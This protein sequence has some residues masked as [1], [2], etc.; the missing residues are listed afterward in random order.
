MPKT[1]KSRSSSTSPPSSPVSPPSPNVQIPLSLLLISVY[2]FLLPLLGGFM[3]DLKPAALRVLLLAAAGV[4]LY[5]AQKPGGKPWNLWPGWPVALFLAWAILTTLTGAGWRS[6]YTTLHFLGAGILTYLL[7]ADAAQTLEGRNWLFGGALAG[8]G[9]TGALALREYLMTVRIDPTWRAFGPFLGPNL[10]ADYLLPCLFLGLTGV[11]LGKRPWMLLINFFTLLCAIGLVLTGSRGAVVYALPVSFLLWALLSHLGRDTSNPDALRTQQYRLATILGVG[12]ILGAFFMKPTVARVGG[13]AT[14]GESDSSQFRLLT[15]K[16]TGTL[17]RER[18]L[19]GWGPGMWEFAYPRVAQAGY[20]KAAHNGYLQIAAEM[21]LPGLALWL[22]VL[23]YGLGGRKRGDMT[24]AGRTAALVAL[25]LHN[26]VDY[27]WLLFAPAGLAWALLG[28]RPK[29]EVRSPKW[30]A[31]V[32]AMAILLTVLGL[33]PAYAEWKAMEAQ[34]ALI[35]RDP[36]LAR[37]A[38]DAAAQLDFT[39]SEWPREEGRLL[40]YT[41]QDPKDAIPYFQEAI[42]RAPMRA[43]LYQA[44]GRAYAQTGQTQNA[45][46]SFETA[47]R[48]DPNATVPLMDFAQLEE[49]LG[50][51]SRALEL[52]RRV[53]AIQDSSAGRVKALADLEDPNFTFARLKLAEDAIQRGDTADA[54]RQIEAGLRTANAYLNGLKIWK[55]VLELQNRYN[56]QEEQ[57]IR[58]AKAQFN[59][60]QQQL[61]HTTTH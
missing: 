20:T 35:A 51:R 43:T 31:G 14:P 46:Q 13:S 7:V 10:L 16:G 49:K 2:L 56:R 4:R 37:Q 9:V 45:L 50:N 30:G 42:R 61:S 40:L 24:E 6:S 25:M 39:E 28:A 1:K 54:K 3:E 53:A 41:L 11:L 12:L 48:L 19:L 36:V 34:D 18:P 22:G 17:I 55:K 32:G 5:E 57:Q 26:G 59:T 47:I 38:Y 8:A 21:G 15:W 27:G 29:S 23:A 33:P 60:W 58:D 52:F 44:L